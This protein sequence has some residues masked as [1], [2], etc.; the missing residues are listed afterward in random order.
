MT[1]TP[2]SD[3]RRSA[4]STRA[5]R[6]DRAR[7]R[8]RVAQPV[9]WA[10]SIRT[11]SL[12]LCSTFILSVGA[13]ALG[14]CSEKGLAPVRAMTY[15]P[16]F[17][18]I[19]R[20]E[21][22]GTMAEFARDVDALDALLAREGGAAS[23]DPGAV[24]GILEHLRAQASALQ[25]GSD[26]NHPHLQHGVERMLRDIQRALDG[27]RLRPP[28]YTWTTRLTGG[29]TACHAPRQPAAV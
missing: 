9:V 28:D 8:P 27:A 24:I 17:H 22:Q 13:L 25:R 21:L 23:A 3:E 5:G 16:D 26:S 6:P 4:G 7:R 12:R 18:Y 15:P 11:R 14:A 1:V 10:R 19:T 29:C 20:A 2:F